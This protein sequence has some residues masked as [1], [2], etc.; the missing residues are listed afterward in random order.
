MKTGTEKEKVGLL[1]GTFNPVHWGH[2]VLARDAMEAHGLSRVV[3][4]PCAAPAHKPERELA[5]AGHRLA[6]LEQ[7]VQDEPAFSVGRDELERGG[8]SYAIDTVRDLRARAP[9]VDWHFIIGAD[10]LLELHSWR[11]IGEL[12]DACRF[13]TMARPGTPPR[14]ELAARLPLP[15]PWPERL[16]QWMF[17]GHLIGISSSE[18]RKRVAESRPIRYLVPRTVEDYITQHRLYRR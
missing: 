12:L 15:A 10:T 2:L 5:P 14:A 8:V 18:I 17:E 13:I 3:F 4:M 9:A 11:A 6:L 7:A 16:T 1:G